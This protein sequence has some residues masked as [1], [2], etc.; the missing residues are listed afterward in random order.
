MCGRKDSN[1]S[2]HSLIW[3]RCAKD[4]FASRRRVHFAVISAAREFNFG[5][6]AS[7]DTASF[8]GFR[9]GKHMQ[10]LGEARMAKRLRNSRK[11]RRDQANKRRDKVPAA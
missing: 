7:Q 1:E 4:R 3:N 10:R 9:A 2:L 5:S 11:Y 8:L 6:A